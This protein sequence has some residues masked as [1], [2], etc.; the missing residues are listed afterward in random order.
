MM[1]AVAPLL[2]QAVEVQH[3]TLYFYNT[4]DQMLYFEPV[5]MLRDPFIFAQTPLQI[6]FEIEE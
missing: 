6:F 2:S 4:W 3:D 1:L 5:S